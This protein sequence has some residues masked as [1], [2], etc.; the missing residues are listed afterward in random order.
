MA[1]LRPASGSKASTPVTC[2]GLPSGT[3]MMVRF[4]P[5]ARLLEPDPEGAAVGKIAE[6]PLQQGHHLLRRGGCG[7]TEP[8]PAAASS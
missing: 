2:P 3:T 1:V 7:H 5:K 4:R 6:H 8:M